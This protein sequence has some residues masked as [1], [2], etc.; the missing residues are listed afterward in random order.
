MQDHFFYPSKRERNQLRQSK[1]A[2]M[3]QQ[4][5]RVVPLEHGVSGLCSEMNSH[6][7]NDFPVFFL[8]FYFFSFGIFVQAIAPDQLDVWDYVARQL[9]ITKATPISKCISY[10]LSPRQLFFTG[11]ELINASTTTGPSDLAPTP[12]SRNS[13]TQSYL[14]INGSTLRKARGI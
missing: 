8:L 5:A 9:M 14:Q 1:V 6:L 7:N 10:V 13:P 2:D 3:P 12:S 4:H 11:Y